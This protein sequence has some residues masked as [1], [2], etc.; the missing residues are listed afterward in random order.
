MSLENSNPIVTLAN[1]REPLEP[2]IE[3]LRSELESVKKDKERLQQELD[4][5]KQAN[6]EQQQGQ[7]QQHQHEKNYNPLLDKFGS[8]I[9]S[10]DWKKS[11]A[12][13]HWVLNDKISIDDV[14][15]YGRTLLSYAAHE[16]AYIMY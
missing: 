13:K 5:L 6:K 16:G 2:D 3:T 7:S 1:D 9:Q 8:I 15:R 14:D 11:E 10:S 4:L 12:I